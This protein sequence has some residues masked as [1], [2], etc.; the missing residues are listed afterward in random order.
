[1]LIFSVSFHSTYI[2][3]LP[4][5]LNYTI[6]AFA[7]NTAIMVTG[8]T[9]HESTTKLQQAADDIA[10]WAHNWLIKLDGT[11]AT[12]ISFTNQKIDQ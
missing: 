2:S 6:A 11:K 9:L 4:E 8:N 1:M 12:Y 10:T 3:D 5:T 7:D